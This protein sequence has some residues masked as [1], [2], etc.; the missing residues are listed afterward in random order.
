MKSLKEYLYHLITDE[1]TQTSSPIENVRDQWVK[2]ILGGVS[3]IYGFVVGQKAL[4]YKLGLLPRVRLPRP[5]ISIGNLT[6]GGAGKTPLVELIVG[7]LKEKK[8]KPVVLTRGYMVRTFAFACEANLEPA[9]PSL[10]LEMAGRVLV[11]K[12]A[13]A[14]VLMV[15]QKR[16]LEKKGISDEGEMLK[17]SLVGVPV[18]TGANRI[19]NAHEALKKYPVDVFILDDGF[20]HWKMARDLDIVAIDTTNPFGNE[21]LI[22]RGIL[23][24]PLKALHR[25]DLFVLTKT[26]F[27]N[28]QMD[29]IKEKLQLINPQAPI[30]ETIHQATGLTKMCESGNPEPLS[31]LN[32]KTVAALCSIAQP[33]SFWN[34]LNSLGADLR[35]MKSFQDH[36]VYERDD[37]LDLLNLSWQKKVNI[38]VTTHKDAVKLKN[39]LQL[40]PKDFLL[41][42]L[43]IKIKITKGEDEFYGRISRLLDR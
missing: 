37:I 32:G 35:I 11:S 15:K 30:V 22:P 34:L 27:G 40:F 19:K 14:K 9:P 18:L 13:N 4:G 36:H 20:G 23:R 10:I 6:W 28:F 5:V 41:F 29:S 16:S 39:F 1:E 7:Y 24:E 8:I 38:L 33:G 25:A 2:A 3:F 12:R 31:F 42:S 26:D 17:E 21:E 43:K